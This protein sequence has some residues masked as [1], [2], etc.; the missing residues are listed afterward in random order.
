MPPL[1][2]LARSPLSTSFRPSRTRYFDYL[3]ALRRGWALTLSSPNAGTRWPSIWGAQRTG[4]GAESRA[5][6]VTLQRVPCMR[7]AARE[8]NSI[9]SGYCDRLGCYPNHKFMCSCPSCAQNA[10]RMTRRDRTHA[11]LMCTND[12]GERLSPRDVEYFD[13]ALTDVYNS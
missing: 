13:R 10:I 7:T 11:S 3:H 4:R 8:Y 5:K 2:H 9:S 6:C 1:H 12:F